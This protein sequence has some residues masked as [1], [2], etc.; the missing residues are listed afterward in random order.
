[1]DEDV[2]LNESNLS[3][4]EVNPQPGKFGGFVNLTLENTTTDDDDKDAKPSAYSPMSISMP[5]THACGQSLST[6]SPSSSHCHCQRH[7]SPTNPP[8]VTNSR[9]ASNDDESNKSN[10]IT[11]PPDG[12]LI[13]ETNTWIDFRLRTMCYPHRLEQ[14]Q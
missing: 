7:S 1:M 4:V 9:T 11:Q 8:L 12:T 13:A 5:T 10:F 2:S 3:V 14:C 6:L